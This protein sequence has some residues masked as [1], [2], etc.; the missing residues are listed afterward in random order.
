VRSALAQTFAALEIVVV[1]D[2]PDTQTS[3][4]VAAIC[5]RRVRVVQLA[6]AVGGSEARNI[7]VRHAR[8][9]WI[10]FL[11]D[12]DEWLPEKLTRQYDAALASRFVE[13]VILGR[14]I[15]RSA[16]GDFVWPRRAPREREPICEYLFCRSGFL[17][18]EGQFQTSVIVARRTLLRRI[19]FTPG[20][21]RNQDI[22]WYL[23]V[24]CAREVGIEFL[25]EPLSVWYFDQTRKTV[26]NSNYD[27]RDTLRWVKANAGLFTARGYAGFIATQL[28]P[29]AARQGAWNAALPLLRE[30]LIHGSPNLLHFALYVSSW[31]TPRWIKRLTTRFS[32]ARLST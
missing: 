27:W 21:R 12:D 5:N 15:G 10:A 16:K 14:F 32:T 2:G 31:L 6:Q 19:P 29:E 24:S 8:G 3:A 13:P 11:D 30:F 22:D 7:G 20:L 9:E 28:A 23:R 1:I 4:A 25:A 26:T 18:G 17:R